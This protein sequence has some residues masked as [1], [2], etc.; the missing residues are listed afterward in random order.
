MILSASRR[1]DIPAFYSEWFCRRLKDGC[2]LVRNPFRPSQ[3]RRVPLTPDLV[4]CIVFWTKNPAPMLGRLDGIARMGFPYYFQFTLTPYGAE[5]ERNL[6]PKEEIIETFRELS[7]KIGPERVV[8]RYDPVI[9][10]KRMPPD[11]HF[12]QFGRLC[13][14]LE[15]CTR[16]CVFSFVD[17]CLNLKRSAAM[18]DALEIAPETMKRVAAGFSGI[19]AEYGLTLRTCCETVDLEEFGIAH[20]SCIDQ[21][22][23]E[24]VAGCPIRVK[25]DKNQRPACGCVESVDIGAYDT[26]RNGCAYCYATSSAGAVL[27]N[28]ALHDPASPLL[29]GR[30]ADG[31]TVLE[32][33]ACSLKDPQTKLF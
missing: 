22:K 1:T 31:E 21:K 10:T 6:P 11:W 3:L 23:I 17:S 33:K 7:A 14:A 32:R 2:A 30:P 8:W 9:V 16:E 4:D 29:L 25:K 15:G 5:I 12:E 20:G 19:A 24:A 13:R 26:C 18:P 27:R 28:A